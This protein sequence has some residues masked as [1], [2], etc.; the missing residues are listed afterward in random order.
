MSN[1]YL[2]YKHPK[3]KE[4]TLENF[5]EEHNETVMDNS[6]KLKS[7]TDVTTKSVAEKLS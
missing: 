5:V 7:F 6:A 4:L 2:I 1:F 3:F